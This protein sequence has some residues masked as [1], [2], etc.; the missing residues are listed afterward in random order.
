M[1]SLRTLLKFLSPLLLVLLVEGLFRL[2]IWEPIAKPSSHAGSSIELKQALSASDFAK[3][4]LVTIGS[5][6]PEFGI[7]HEQLTLDAAEHGINYANASMPGT[8]WMT[9]GV[10]GGWL[11]RHHPE[12]QGGI[13]ALSIQDFSYA[14]NGDY[15]L[16]I[17]T[18][19]RTWHDTAEIK[20]SV[21]FNW[22][23]V[24]T[25]GAYSSLF[26]WRGDVQDLLRHPKQRRKA[27][28]SAAKRDPVAVL[29]ENPTLD[30]D[31]CAIGVNDP[32]ACETVANSPDP[33]LQ[34]LAG[35]CRQ[36]NANGGQRQDLNRY[37]R[38][39][40]LPDS[41]RRARDLI[42]DRLRGL[43]WPQPPVVVLMPTTGIWKNHTL[44]KG[45]HDWALEILRPLVDDGTI[46]VVD[47]TDALDGED[48][49]DC[50]YFA[51]FYHQNAAGRE[52]FAEWLEPQ[53]YPLL[54]GEQAAADASN[55]TASH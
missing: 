54:F 42:R 15:E 33:T 52:A 48:G 26:A 23:D 21:A 10:L 44:P 30:G 7:D 37:P 47:G 18:P 27:L 31:M 16:G 51:D 43:A 32:A 50:R 38:D 5:S 2:G 6:R 34:R 1:P 41:M 13:V 20:R 24:D 36:L 49:T 45:Q 12:I 22:H 17:V 35:Q 11:Q 39:D 29:Q 25:W 3:I 19:L 9:V 4:G 28:R 53:L 14:G 8:H 46:R 40:R 55:D